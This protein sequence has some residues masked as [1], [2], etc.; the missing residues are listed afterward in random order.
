MIARTLFVT[1]TDTGVGK[2]RVAATVLRTLRAAGVDAVGFKPVASGAR[3]TA[4]GLRNTDALALLRAGPRTL[5]Y[6]RVNPFCF[7]PPIAPH[8]AALE[9]GRR[10]TS[11]QLDRAHDWLSRRH[12][13]V[14]VEGAGGWHVPLNDD[15]RLSDWVRRRG[16]PVLL[17]V[18]LRLGCLNHAMLS[19]E[20]IGSALCGWVANQTPPRLSRRTANLDALTRRLPAPLWFTLRRG[21]P[22]SAAARRL[23]GTRLRALVFTSSPSPT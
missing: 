14:V 8:L 2:T 11:V 6:R 15:E 22:P 10:L 16:W 19:A 4:E 20:A 18:G 21:E 1:G 13:V 9:A 12:S 23:D 5:A 17:V 7:A 3:R